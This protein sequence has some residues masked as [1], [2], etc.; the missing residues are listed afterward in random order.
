M[1]EYIIVPSLCD[2]LQKAKIVQ[3]VVNC[4]ACRPTQ[5]W[6]EFM[7]RVITIYIYQV[8]ISDAYIYIYIYIYIY[9]YI[10]ISQVHNIADHIKS[11]Q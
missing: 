6:V 8:F 5:T 7:V 4:H 3:L 10:Y 1:R 9:K 2:E 11:T